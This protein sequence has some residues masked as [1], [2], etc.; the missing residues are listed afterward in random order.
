MGQ[1]GRYE[2]FMIS[3]TKRR[4]G[5]GPKSVLATQLDNGRRTE[6]V[7]VSWFDEQTYTVAGKTEGVP[8]TISLQIAD[9]FD[10]IIKPVSINPESFSAVPMQWSTAVEACER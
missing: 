4:S 5:K 10:L 3:R 6:L 7:N 1:D 8:T 2:Q 9:E